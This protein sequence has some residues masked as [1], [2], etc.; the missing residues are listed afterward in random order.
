MECRSAD[1]MHLILRCIADDQK[2]LWA[3]LIRLQET[4]REFD[5]DPCPIY[6]TS[7]E[8]A[9]HNAEQEALDEYKGHVDALYAE[10]RCF[11]IGSVKTEDYEIS[12]QLMERRREEW[13]GT[14]MKRPFPF[15][16]GAHSYYLT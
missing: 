5:D 15:Y 4:W 13:D 16:E 9:A 6:F 10:L 7:D 8:I 2:A 12:K 14:A 11:G 1:S 3:D